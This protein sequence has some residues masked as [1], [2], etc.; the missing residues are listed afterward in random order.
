MKN[1]KPDPSALTA[2]LDSRARRRSTP[3]RYRHCLIADTVVSAGTRSGFK[4]ALHVLCNAF[5][6]MEEA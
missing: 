6:H 3:A 5:N 1:Q 2:R 4:Q